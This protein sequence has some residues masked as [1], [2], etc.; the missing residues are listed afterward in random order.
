SAVIA[1]SSRAYAEGTSRDS[2]TVAGGG[3]TTFLKGAPGTR[4]GRLTGTDAGSVM[5]RLLFGS[6]TARGRGA[7]ERHQPRYRRS[8]ARL[9]IAGN[10]A[11]AMSRR[12]RGETAADGERGSGRQRVAIDFALG[13]TRQDEIELSL[14]LE[15]HMQHVLLVAQLK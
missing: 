15:A 10:V 4:A 9:H 1:R 8:G 6:L 7:I 2:G 12:E 3:S 5:G 13:E 11:S 14:F